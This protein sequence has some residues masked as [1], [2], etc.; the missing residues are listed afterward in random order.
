M[1]S[2]SVWACDVGG[3]GGGGCEHDGGRVTDRMLKGNDLTFLT[4]LQNH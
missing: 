3:D 4:F 2:D 1:D